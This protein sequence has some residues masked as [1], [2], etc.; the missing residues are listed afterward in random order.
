[1]SQHL[2][3]FGFGKLPAA[4]KTVRVD[5]IFTSVAGYYDLMN[6][7]MSGGLHRLWK[8]QLSL[9]AAARPGQHW[10]DLACGSGDIANLCRRACQQDGSITLADPCAP[11]LAHAQQRFGLNNFKF[12]QCTAEQLPFRDA[13]FDGITCAFGFRNFTDQ[14][15][16]LKQMARVLK[17]GGKM[18]ILEFAHPKPCLRKAHRAYL[19]NGLPSLGKLV[20]NDEA[21]YRYLGE[22]ILAQPSQAQ[23]VKMIASTGLEFVQSHDLTGGV[24]AI[25]EARRTSWT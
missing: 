6:D 20:A 22:S 4:E 2:S 8:R 16:G 13:S 5:N 17:P 7:L 14:M 10:L 24:V 23:T 11:M 1:M 25:Y 18:L 12:I 3:Q 15:A 9:L 21:S 19:L